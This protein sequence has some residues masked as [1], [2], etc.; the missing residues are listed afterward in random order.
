MLFRKKE[1][2]LYES[3]ALR[4]YETLLNRVNTAVFYTQWDVPDTLDGRFDLLCLHMFLVMEH[5]LAVADQGQ[6]K[7]FNQALF[8]VMFANMD[9]TLRQRGIGDMGVPKHMR[10]MMKGFNGRMHAYAAVIND[11][12]ALEE[13]VR[14]NIYNDD[15]NNEHGVKMLLRYVRNLRHALDSQNIED[16]MNGQ[17]SLPSL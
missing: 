11:D 14:R 2:D 16:M 15:T 8:D 12:S 3:A 9:Q 5:M 10:R 6:A 13:T 4:V 1:Q 7:A 17:I